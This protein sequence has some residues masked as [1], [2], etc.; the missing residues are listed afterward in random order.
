MRGDRRSG[1]NAPQLRSAWGSLPLSQRDVARLYKRF[2]IRRVSSIPNRQPDVVS[3][4]RPIF[5]RWLSVSDRLFRDHEAV[6]TLRSQIPVTENTSPKTFQAV[7]GSPKNVNPATAMMAIPPA[8]T[9]GP[10]TDSSPAIR[11]M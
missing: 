3:P 7:S 9:M 8:N 10:A 6:E 2:F 4:W 1:D 5:S 11:K